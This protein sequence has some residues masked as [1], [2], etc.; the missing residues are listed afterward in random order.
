[1]LKY[2]NIEKLNEN[3]EK[4]YLITFRFRP[5]LYDKLKQLSVSDKMEHK[6]RPVRAHCE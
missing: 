6:Q 5:L 2:I 1:M 4:D 3:I